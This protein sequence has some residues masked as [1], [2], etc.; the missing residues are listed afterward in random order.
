MVSERLR[1]PERLAEEAL[2]PARL[3][4]DPAHVTSGS[5]TVAEGEMRV[6]RLMSERQD[7]VRQVPIIVEGRLLAEEGLLRPIQ[8]GDGGLR[9][10]SL[11]EFHQGA[12]GRRWVAIRELDEREKALLAVQIQQLLHLLQ[13][14]TPVRRL[15]HRPCRHRVADT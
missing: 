8:V 14:V 6:T 4:L 11:L 9:V 2:G 5:V 7:T 3:L 1:E 13:R 10:S 15:V 12:T